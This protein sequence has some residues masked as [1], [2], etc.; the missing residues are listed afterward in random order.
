MGD[1]NKLS[2][3]RRRAQRSAKSHQERNSWRINQ[4]LTSN[5]KLQLEMI[6]KDHRTKSI[7][8]Q[9]EIKDLR[10]EVRW[11]VYEADRANSEIALR[12]QQPLRPATACDRPK[13]SLSRTE[14]FLIPR[15]PMSAPAQST[16]YRPSSGFRHRSCYACSR[17]AVLHLHFTPAPT[18]DK[19]QLHND[20]KVRF[21]LAP[22]PVVKT[23]L[24]RER[25]LSRN[26]D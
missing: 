18:C 9:Q 17:A 1:N 2:Q 26:L 8:L 25:Y 7:V 21:A 23:W 14:S 16:H 4:N 12:K 10:R 24:N 15:R 20:P 3:N 19:P 13:S 6:H 22:P 5:L 11:R